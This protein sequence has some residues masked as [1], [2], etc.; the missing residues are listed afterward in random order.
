MAQIK[1]LLLVIDYQTD[2]VSGSLGFNEAVA[3]EDGIC[4]RIAHY[5]QTEGE[6]WF[7]MDTHDEGYLQ[8]NEGTLLPIPHCIKGTPGWELYGRTASLVGGSPQI[9]KNDFG[10]AT[11]FNRLEA[12]PFDEIELIG[13]VTN[14]CVITNAVLAKTACPNARVSVNQALTASNDR[15]LHDMAISVM[16]SFQINII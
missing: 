8:T 16:K 13:V 1:K 12:T 6:V 10:S 3:I 9:V 2:F 15:E 14:I 5:R 7:T 11:L 4:E